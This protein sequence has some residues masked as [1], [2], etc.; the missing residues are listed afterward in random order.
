[1]PSV[2]H[3]R[4]CSLEDTQ[5]LVQTSI[6]MHKSRQRATHRQRIDSSRKEKIT[7]DY[8]PTN[9]GT[10]GEPISIIPQRACDSLACRPAK[11]K[12]GQCCGSADLSKPFAIRQLQ[13]QV[14]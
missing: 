5:C 11:Q 13:P 14:Q 1:M 8:G 10:R 6:P 12:N 4:V 3:G 7:T 9:P 2:S